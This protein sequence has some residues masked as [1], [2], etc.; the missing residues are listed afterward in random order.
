MAAPIRPIG[1]IDVS[2]KIS[3]IKWFPEEKVKGIPGMSGSAGH[4]RIRLAHFLVTLTDYDGVNA[5]TARTMT[6]YLDW[7]A[8]KG[9][10]QRDKPSFILLKINH[11]DKAYLRQGM[12]IRVIGYEVRGDEGGTWT[13][14]DKVE[15]PGQLSHDDNIKNYLEKYIE[16][17]GFGGRMFCAYELFG[18]EQKGNKN[19]IY[20]WTLCM[21]Y[22]MKG[23]VLMKG[24][25]VS[26]PLALISAGLHRQNK[27]AEHRK[28]VDGEGYAR[29]IREIFPKKYH[30]VIFAEATEYN[31]RAESLLRDTE[32][33]ARIYYHL[34]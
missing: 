26:M 12:K 19:Y 3:Q 10:K 25:G 2:G 32:R 4:D 34:E 9:E 24:T 1:P 27:I 8:L 21:E 16:T 22:Y 17:P 5:E 30:K 18:T 20:L 6:R 7:T 23:R 33:Q 29:S 15:I 31:K 11:N 13:Y 28:P 14:Y